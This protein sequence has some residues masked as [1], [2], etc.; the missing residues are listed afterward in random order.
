MEGNKATQNLQHKIPCFQFPHIFPKRR[1]ARNCLYVARF[2]LLDKRGISSNLIHA[3]TLNLR[4]SRAAGTPGF[5]RQLLRTFLY[6]PGLTNIFTV[7]Q[8]KRTFRIHHLSSCKRKRS[9]INGFLVQYI[10]RDLFSSIFF[11]SLQQ[12]FRTLIIHS[13]QIFEALEFTSKR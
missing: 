2:T 13:H 1:F 9:G 10:I 4:I 8:G 7:I 11:T 12:D 3:S 6:A 5:M